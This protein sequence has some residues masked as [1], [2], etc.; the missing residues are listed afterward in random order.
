M[1]RTGKIPGALEVVLREAALSDAEARMLVASYYMSQDMR[2]R[3]DMQIRHLGDRV[4][5]G[6]DVGRSSQIL[7]FTAD[8]FATIEDGMRKAIQRYAE[9]SKVGRWLLSQIGIGPVIAG[10]LLAHLDIRVAETAGHFWTFAGLNPN[11]RSWGKGEKRPYN[12]QLKQICWHLGNSFQKTCNHKESVYGPLYKIRKERLVED[13]EEL[14][15]SERAK[16]FV[17]KSADVR[18]MLATGRLPLGN[19]DQQARNYAAKILLSHL[20]A[21]MYWNYYNRI[22][23]RP[24]AIAILGHA[25]EIKVP[26]TE[27][28]F[29]GFA[30]A[31][32]GAVPA[33]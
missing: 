12:A 1:K 28:E 32:Y 33:E 6:K 25:H 27:E 2:K 21:V 29:P 31:Y 30:R 13:N 14:K 11:K 24:F 22:P 17:T 23:P 5:A 3:M 8:Q 7:E 26:G 15:F 4:A 9:G 18:N 19:L 20:H 10:G 16:I